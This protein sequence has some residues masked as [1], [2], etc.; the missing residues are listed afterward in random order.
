MLA[1]R[2][3]AARMDLQA[4]LARIGLARPG[5]ASLANLVRLHEAHTLAIP[6][7]NLDVLLERPIRLDLASLERKLVHERRGGYCFE[8]NGLFAAVLRELGYRVTTLGARVRYFAPA[9]SVTACSHMV[10]RVDCPEGPQLADVGFGGHGPTAPVPWALFVERAQRLDTF[11]LVTSAA[12]TLLQA[13]SQGAWLDLY[14]IGPEELHP[15]DYEVANWFTSTHPS[16]RFVQ[17]LAVARP[18]ADGRWTLRNGV[19]ALRRGDVVEETPMRTRPEL[20]AAL[21]RLFGIVLPED[22]RLRV[23]VLAAPVPG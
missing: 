14:E 4:Y 2:G 22:A 13:R 10:L 8:Q 12:G 20:F 5:E 3:D 7:E 9:G 15:I 17:G 1:W 18:T 23:D 6:F 11:R 19:L 16:S 21:A